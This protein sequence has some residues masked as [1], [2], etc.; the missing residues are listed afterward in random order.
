MT[1]TRSGNFFFSSY[2]R[3]GILLSLIGVLLAIDSLVREVVLYKLWPLLLTVLGTGFI[4]IYLQRARREGSYFGVGIFITGLSGIFLYC[5]FV[6]W[7]VL[8]T[9]W[10]IFI[11]LLG[12]SMVTCYLFGKRRPAI[13]LSGLLFLSLATAFYLIFSCNTRLWWSTFILAGCSFMIFDKARRF[14]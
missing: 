14:R 7:S 8:A 5:N 4:G 11:T 12:L 2:G 13:L 1:K 3:L 10:P 6:S 9:L